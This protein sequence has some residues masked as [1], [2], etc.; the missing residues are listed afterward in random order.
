MKYAVAVDCCQFPLLLQ[1]RSVSIK[2]NLFL[3][4]EICLTVK[5][6]LGKDGCIVTVSD[7]RDPCFQD[8]ISMESFD[9]W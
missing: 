1:V 7:S 8:F 3:I 5:F 6:W 9:I 4:Y 2:V